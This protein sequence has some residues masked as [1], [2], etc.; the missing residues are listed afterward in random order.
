MNKVCPVKIAGRELRLVTEEDESY[1]L[2]LAQR[3]NNAIN[4]AVTANNG[5][6]KFDAALLCALDAMDA[7]IKASSRARKLSEDN[8]RLLEQLNR[9]QKYNGRR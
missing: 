6:A 4:E 5:A 9:A 7:A 3:L 8:A 1:V 2:E